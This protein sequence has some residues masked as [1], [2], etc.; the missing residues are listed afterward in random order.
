MA[1]A[2]FGLPIGPYGA[3]TIEGKSLLVQPFER[4]RLEYH[5]TTPRPYDV[6]LGRLGADL[7]AQQGRDWFTFPKGTPQEGC[8][9][10]SATNH[11]V[12]GDFLQAFSR[13]RPRSGP[14][15]RHGD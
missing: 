1:F 3:V 4:N 5:P 6:Q 2:V 15:R 10:F 7:L 12:C 11:T 9:F 14:N 8:R 13:Q